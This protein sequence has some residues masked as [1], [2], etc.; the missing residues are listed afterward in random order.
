MKVIVIYDSLYGNTENVARALTLGIR[1]QGI[2]VDCVRANTI[3]VEALGAYDMIVIGG[4]THAFGL[5][6]T[7]KTF[8]PLTTSLFT[9]EIA[10]TPTAAK[11]AKIMTKATMR[12]NN[13][14]FHL[15]C[16]QSFI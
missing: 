4:P 12:T 2:E 14:C 6:E 16:G 7:M 10:Y 11:I 5:S 8:P 3:D 1:E 15:F 13:T 9:A